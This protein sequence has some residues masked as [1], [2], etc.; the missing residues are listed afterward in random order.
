MAAW[1][2]GRPRPQALGAGHWSSGPGFVPVGLAS[3]M[4]AAAASC[5]RRAR[6]G[7]SAL[8]GLWLLPL[9]RQRAAA[10]GVP[11]D[12]YRPYD[13]RGLY[14]LAACGEGRAA[15]AA[16]ASAS[17]ELWRLEGAGCTLL[18]E[19][20]PA[21][22][23]QPGCLQVH[24][25]CAS[26]EPPRGVVAVVAEDAGAW[27]RRAGVPQRHTAAPSASGGREVG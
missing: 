8:V 5:R 24:A 16:A 26:G 11:P 27:L 3:R 20:A 25:V 6:G 7:R 4:A 12:P 19:P 10:E 15:L 21:G 18:G 13:G 14:L 2:H 9:L 1:P 17:E 23:R 22:A